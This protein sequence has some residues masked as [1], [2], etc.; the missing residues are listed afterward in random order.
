MDAATGTAE[1]ELL[2]YSKSN[3]GDADI[4]PICA[5]IS[6]RGV[7]FR[8]LDLS[9]NSIGDK[10]CEALAPVISS[11]ASLHLVNLTGNKVTDSGRL[12][13]FRS[14]ASARRR[15]D[16]ILQDN[17][18]RTVRARPGAVKRP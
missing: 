14:L 5:A 8:V 17:G 10:G 15:C 13:L 3:L 18:Q 4:D 1:S 11:I 2:D 6:S 16:V 9:H 7:N 12:V